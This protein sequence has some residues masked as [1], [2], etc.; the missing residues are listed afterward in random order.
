MKTFSHFLILLIIVSCSSPN[1][2]DQNEILEAVDTMAVA[3][4]LHEEDVREILQRIPSP[5][6]VAVLLKEVGSKYNPEILNSS[7]GHLGYN[8]TFKKAINLGI[9][10]TDL[11]YTNIYQHNED[12]IAYLGAIRTLA[13]DLSI[14]QFFDFE[15][16]AHLATNSQNIDSLLLITT[17]NWN[18]INRYLQDQ[19]RSKVSILL[20]AGGW[21]EALHICS[22]VYSLNPGN[23]ELRERIGEQK[24]IMENIML[25]LSFYGSEDQ[26][27]Q[28]LKNQMSELQKVFD[29]VTISYVYQESTYEVVDGIL[30]IHDNSSSSIEVTEEN[31]NNIARHTASIRNQVIE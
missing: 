22:Q 19:N 10:G 24:I 27:M 21:L 15:V 5:L 18:D 7:A 31:I 29:E 6:E 11:G 17:Q 16:I 25:L 30:M 9:Y 8:T 1:K 14:G 20:L 2:P 12:A 26:N 13:D 28:K 3:P 4:A 23:V